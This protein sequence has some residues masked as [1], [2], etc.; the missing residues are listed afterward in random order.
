MAV[1][2]AEHYEDYPSAKYFS[3]D[4]EHLDQIADY[5]TYGLSAEKNGS[6]GYAKSPVTL[7]W[8]DIYAG[9]R[10]FDTFMET[11]PLSLWLRSYIYLF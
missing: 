5:E 3:W 11:C 6:R 7:Y 9:Y 10:Y 1:T 8:E 4:K 2:V